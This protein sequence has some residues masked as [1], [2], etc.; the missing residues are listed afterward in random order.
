MVFPR[1]L[2]FVLLNFYCFSLFAF[3]WQGVYK[4]INQGDL[5]EAFFCNI[6]EDAS[7]TIILGKDGQGSFYD[8][9]GT[10][11]PLK[12]KIIDSSLEIDIKE[13]NIKQRSFHIAGA[14]SLITTIQFPL[15]Y[16]YAVSHDLSP[17]FQTDLWIDC[18]ADPGSYIPG[19]GYS[20]NLFILS[21]R[22][23]WSSSVTAII[24]GGSFRRKN[25]ETKDD[26]IS[27][28][29]YGVYLLK[30][31]KIYIYY[32]APQEQMLFTGSFNADFSKVLINE[33]GE[34]SS[35]GQWCQVTY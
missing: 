32:G 8:I 21:R 6:S 17:Q 14:E 23:E 28:H 25:T 16:C 1:L 26:T 31:K 19:V 34:K 3:D 22:K 15:A 5:N 4:K 20:S 13:K 2:L 33:L 11:S 30:D 18:G 12:H 29:S 27:N 9:Y 7:V 10:Y 24:P 35:G